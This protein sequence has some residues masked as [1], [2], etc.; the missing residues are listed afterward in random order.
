MEKIRRMKLLSQY[1]NHVGDPRTGMQPDRPAGCPIK[2]G[3]TVKHRGFPRAIRANQRG[4]RPSFDL[5]IDIIERF[6]A[7][8]M[9]HQM[10]NLQNIVIHGATPFRTATPVRLVRTSPRGRQII[11]STIRRQTAAPDIRRTP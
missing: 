11:I 7:A 8:K 6:N 1:L 5:K 9:H 3:Q 2:P 4:N 10:L